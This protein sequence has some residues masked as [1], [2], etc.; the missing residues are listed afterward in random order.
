MVFGDYE[1]NIYF[2]NRQLELMVFRGY[3]IRVS[4]LYQ[5]KQHSILV[6]IGVRTFPD[7]NL[8]ANVRVL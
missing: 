6:S 5:L 2:L 4:H 3:E 8:Q 7:N 1:G